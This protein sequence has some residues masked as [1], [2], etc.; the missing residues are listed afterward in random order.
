MQKNC[1]SYPVEITEDVFGESKSLAKALYGVAGGS[2]PRVLLVADM[3]VVNRTEGL[4]SKIGRYFQTHSIKMI[5]NPVVVPGGEKI[6]T[7]DMQCARRVI[8]AMLDAKLGV[9]DAV[10]VLGGGSVIDVAGYA[11]AQVRGGI[12][13]VRIPTTVAAMVDGAYST[14]SALDG[15]NVKDAL[16][17]ACNPAAVLVDPLFAKTIL[18]GVWRGG[19]SEAVRLAVMSD[20][21]YFKTL[22]KSA[23]DYFKRDYGVMRELVCKAVEIR[24]KKG[25]TPFAQWAAARLESMSSYKLPHGYAVAIAICIDSAY[26]CAKGYMKESEHEAIGALL[27]ECGA[28]DALQHSRHLLDQSESVLFGLDGW[29]LATGSSEITLPGGIGKRK[30]EPA[31]DRELYGKVMQDFAE[32]AASL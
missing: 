4:G 5:A 10:I 31:P 22:V 18:D 11:A 25:D 16:R 8:S 2:E 14:Y 24:G 32:V 28:L 15:V 9:G 23:G 1:F 13:Q 21:S 29:R 17:V 27:R 7:D 19:V 26:A 3:N 20:A 30:V 6:K 12:A